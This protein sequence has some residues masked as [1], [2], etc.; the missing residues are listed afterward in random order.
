MINQFING[1]K[2][3][4]WEFYYHNNLEY[5]NGNLMYKGHYIN[6]I[7]EGYWESYYYNGNLEE[8]EIFI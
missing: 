2:Q 8:Q 7:R 4:P 3:G 6:D 5:Y 1:K